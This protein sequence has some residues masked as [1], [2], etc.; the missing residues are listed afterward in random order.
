M[1][2][3]FF[4]VPLFKLEPIF[5][6]WMREVQ[7]ENSAIAGTTA[8]Q[9]ELKTIDEAADFLRLSKATLYAMTSAKAI[10]FMKRGKRIY[11]SRTELMDYLKE[12]RSKT[13]AEQIADAGQILKKKGGAH[14]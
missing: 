13:R 6:K 3:V 8:P 7:A 9:D 11:F 1:E 2:K 5:K 10:P 4:Y 14:E 12:G